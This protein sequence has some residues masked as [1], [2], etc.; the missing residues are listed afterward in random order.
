M[1]KIRSAVRYYGSFICIL[2]LQIIV[3]TY[4]GIQKNWLFGD[5]QWTFNLANRYYEPFLETIDASPYYGKW[6]S[7]DFWNSVLTVNPAYGFNYGSVFY[8]QSLDVHPPLYYLIIHTICSFFP[9]IYSKWFGIIPNI[10]FF[11]LSQF[12]IYNI[13][14]LIFKKRYTA[15]LL[16]LFY[17]FSWG[18]INNA[19]YVR[20]Y[21]LLS[22]WAVISYYLH[23]KLMNRFNRNSLIM[24]LLFSLLGILTQ[25]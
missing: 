2:A 7:P 19:V 12:V 10:V 16:C 1:E 5:E 8:N 4:F 9:N 6:L 20:M 25:Y 11:L 17:G 18:V 13:G 24:V 21:G 15:L 23:L 14:T 3:I 22:L